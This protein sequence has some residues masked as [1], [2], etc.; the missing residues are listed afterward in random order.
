MIEIKHVQYC[1]I[2]K[3]NILDSRPNKAYAMSHKEYL[4]FGEG[5]V[6]VTVKTDKV[7][8]CDYILNGPFPP[9]LVEIRDY[10]RSIPFKDRIKKIKNIQKSLNNIKKFKL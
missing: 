3:S 5:Y 2:G 10:F 7:E 9:E 6:Y 4:N 1:D 8:I